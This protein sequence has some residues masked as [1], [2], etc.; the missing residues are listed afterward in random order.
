[1]SGTSF[2]L[3]FLPPATKY[4]PSGRAHKY[5]VGA[6]TGRFNLLARFCAKPESILP[7]L[8]DSKR[9]ALPEDSLL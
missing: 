8:H 7:V 4:V 1:M 6:F 5:S 3:I 9:M 2:P